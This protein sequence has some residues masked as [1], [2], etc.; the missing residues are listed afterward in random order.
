MCIRPQVEGFD[1]LDFSKL[2][3]LID[4]GRAAATEALPALRAR[5]REAARVGTA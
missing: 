3:Q 1:Q 2:D 5:M 4:V